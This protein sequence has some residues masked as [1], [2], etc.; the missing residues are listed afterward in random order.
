MVITTA[1]ATVFGWG[2]L[3]L[4]IYGIVVLIASKPED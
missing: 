3:A 4:L 2:L 1:E